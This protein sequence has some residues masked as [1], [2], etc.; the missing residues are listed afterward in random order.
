[1]VLT[2]PRL[3]TRS[4]L[5]MATQLVTATITHPTEAKLPTMERRLTATT[6]QCMA[7]Q[8]VRTTSQLN[9]CSFKLITITILALLFSRVA[10][11]Y[12]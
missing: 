1:M 9:L 11:Q 6:R 10:D 7:T 3:C 2:I 8:W 5:T 4:I 12:T